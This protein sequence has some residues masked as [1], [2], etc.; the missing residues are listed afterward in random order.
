MEGN[1]VSNFPQPDLAR[2]D[3]RFARHPTTIVD[4]TL[5]KALRTI[6]R[7]RP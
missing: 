6:M 4:R 2:N 1:W 3:F 5:F 7:F